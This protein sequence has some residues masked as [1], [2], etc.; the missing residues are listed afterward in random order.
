MT[1]RS[2]TWRDTIASV[3]YALALTNFLGAT[4]FVVVGINPKH[5]QYGNMPWYYATLCLLLTAPLYYFSRRYERL[6]SGPMNN[7]STNS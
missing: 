4:L 1:Q 3:L 6:E 5:D 7:T 2:S